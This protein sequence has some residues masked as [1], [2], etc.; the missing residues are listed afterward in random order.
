HDYHLIGVGAR[1]KEVGV[2]NTCAFFLHTPFPSPD[3]F[4]KLPWRREMLD[5]LLAYDLIGFQT[6]RDRRNFLQTYNELYAQSRSLNEAAST[7]VRIRQS[8]VGTF[9]IAIDFQE[10]DSQARLPEIVERAEQV[11]A[12]AKVENIILSVDRLDYTK[13]I[14]ARIVAFG[15]LLRKH[16]EL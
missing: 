12:E 9:P 2:T 13:G 5:E 10:F 1:L 3:I 8:V 7:H 6:T 16:P 15:R 14:P 11:R 4:L